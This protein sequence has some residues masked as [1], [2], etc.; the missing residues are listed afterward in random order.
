MGLD[1]VPSAGRRVAL[2]VTAHLSMGG[3]S[4]DCT[5]DICFEN[6]EM[7][8][9]AARVTGLDV[10]GVD[11]ICSHPGQPLA[12]SGGVVLEVNASPGL[13]AHLA[14][15]EGR[16]RDVAAP[17]LDMLFPPGRPS[18]IPI[19][20]I[21]GTNGKTTTSRMCAHIL[22]MGGHK[23]G[24]TTTDGIYVDGTLLRSGDMT[25]PWS[26]QMVLRD[27]TIDVAVLETAR[28]GILRAGLGFDRCDV[29]AVLNVSDDHLGL[30]AWTPSR[31]WPA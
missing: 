28:G 22:K 14:P 2:K 29:G 21:T 9:R 17:I 1:S 7:A 26:A 31:T 5:D 16:P 20:A 30:E 18:R 3:A 24:L 15:T 19:I 25:G 11:V 10:A 6:V 4:V 23:V 8:V 27:P 12:D 13:R